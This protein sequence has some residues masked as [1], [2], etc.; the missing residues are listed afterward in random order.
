MDSNSTATWNLKKFI[1]APESWRSRARKQAS[2]DGFVTST[3]N[4]TIGL[5][6]YWVIWVYTYIWR[7]EYIG[8]IGSLASCNAKHCSTSFFAGAYSLADPGI[9][10]RSD[11]AWSKNPRPR[12]E[13]CKTKWRKAGVAQQ[14]KCKVSPR[15]WGVHDPKV[16]NPNS[17]S[18]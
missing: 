7:L 16:R 13:A 8:Q 15:P 11:S 4:W 6:E 1:D 5:W 18:F 12:C 17:V 3:K 9:A 2:M 10:L 14:A